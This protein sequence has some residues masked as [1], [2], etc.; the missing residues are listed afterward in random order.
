MLEDKQNIGPE[1]NKGAPEPKPWHRK[2]WLRIVAL[3]IVVG[4]L[5]S[6]LLSRIVSSDALVISENQ[7]TQTLIDSDLAEALKHPMELSDAYRKAVYRQ[8]LEEQ[9]KEKLLTLGQKAEEQIADG[10][11]RKAVSTLDELL[12]EVTEDEADIWQLK[13]IRAQLLF[14]DGQKQKSE[15]ACAEIIDAQMD[16]GGIAHFIRSLI[17]LADEDY[18][19]AREDILGALD[20][21]Y[22]QEDICDLHLAYCDYYL[23]DY[24]SVLSYTAQAEEEGISEKYD[25]TILYLNAMSQLQLARYEDSIDSITKLLEMEEEKD[26]D[27]S[28]LYYRGVCSLALEDYKSSIADFK[29]AQE[30]GFGESKD[31]GTKKT[32]LLHNLGVAYAGRGKPKKAKKYMQEVISRGDDETLA[33]AAQDL[34]DMYEEAEKAAGVQ[35]DT[36]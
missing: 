7:Q 10:E 13:I 24:E 23:E 3:V 22:P 32:M 36:E 16:E 34:L 1:L 33:K 6:E 11:Y 15:Q 31:D 8:K 21:G 4:M 29:A 30:A 5:A 14:S 20:A 18:A 17:H 19:S 25:Y 27:G 28:L 12:G 35:P 26:S 9:R 2:T